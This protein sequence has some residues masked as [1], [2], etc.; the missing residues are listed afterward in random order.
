[1]DEDERR[2]LFA[3]PPSGDTLTM[4]QPKQA[5]EVT[6]TKAPWIN[7]DLTVK[8]AA[9]GIATLIAVAISILAVLALA[10]L[11]VWWG[12]IGNPYFYALVGF[13]IIVVIGSAI[14]KRWP[15]H[16]GVQR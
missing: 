8:G 13:S 12:L 15:T 10:L 1:M 7:P 2:W 11:F 3:T 5:V 4:P 9:V 6:T 14:K 16:P